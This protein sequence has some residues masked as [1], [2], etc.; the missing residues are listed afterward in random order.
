MLVL[1][2]GTAE[3]ELV[4]PAT[5]ALGPLVLVLGL[6]DG[7]NAPTDTGLRVKGVTDGLAMPN[8]EG[9]TLVEVGRDRETL[10]KGKDML[11]GPSPFPSEEGRAG[12]DMQ[13]FRIAL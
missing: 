2:A 9:G 4:P 1:P 5:S 12:D 10:I 7:G 11:G 6:P 8:A 13:C 3:V